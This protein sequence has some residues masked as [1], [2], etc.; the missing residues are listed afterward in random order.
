[1][2]APAR[3]D[4]L[5]L[6]SR[7][8]GSAAVP[9]LVLG[10]FVTLRIVNPPLLETARLQVFDAYVRLAPRHDAAAPV[11]VVDID[12]DTLAAFGQWPWPRT[13]IAALVQKLDGLGAKTIAFDVVFA[14]PDRTSPAEASKLWDASEALKAEARKLPDHEVMLAEAMQQSR[15]VTGFALITEAPAVEVRPSLRASIAH[16]G[17]DPREYVPRLAG[18][19]AN[20]PILEQAS[21]G[22]GHLTLL[23]ESDGM[24]RR[25]PLLLRLG[26]QLYPSL[27]AEALRVAQGASTYVV[28]STGASGEQYS[29]AHTGIVSVKIGAHTVPTDANGRLWIYYARR[30]PART[31]P[32]W[33]VLAGQADASMIH[34]AIVFIG[35]SAIGLKDIRTTPVNPAMA[36]VE[37]HAQAT[38]QI[39]DGAFLARP[40]WADG[41]ETVWLAGLGAL[42]LIA[43]PRAGAVACAGIGAAGIAVALGVSW[44]AFT[45]L[46][47]LL[48]PV[49]PSVAVLGLYLV[50]SFLNFLRTEAERRHVRQA[51]SR[52]LAPALVDRLAKHPEQLRLGGERRTMT[53]LFADIRGFTS[54]AEQ[55]DAE[56]LGRFMNRFLTPMTQIVLAHQGTIDKYVGDC[57]MAFWNAPFDDALH[58]RHACHAALQMRSHLVVFNQQMQADGQG[59]EAIRRPVHIGIGINTGSCTVGNF[60]SEQRFDYSVLGDPVNLASRLEGQSNIYGSD[61]ILGE[62]AREQ[63]PELAAIELDLIL[64][65]GRQHPVRIYA[66]IGDAAMA[67]DERFQSLQRHHAQLLQAYREQKWDEASASLETCLSLDTPRIR[68]RRLYWLYR[69]RI[70]AYRTNPPAEAW[71]GVWSGEKGV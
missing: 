5:R 67:S 42:L 27:A 41:A 55:F 60:G 56:G 23:A 38:E 35:T 49:M 10:V 48:D 43:L 13:L 14:E 4:T 26:D 2:T 29:N 68:L 28:K 12:D 66:L 51:F 36:G 8:L 62:M 20:L 61:I 64:V 52:Y 69:S 22:N 16:A 24:T 57:I 21:T 33:E 31:V 1:V 54:L 18:A 37:V 39:L 9:L 70:E 19:V 50:A 30:D 25:V 63:V 40:D 46:R 59:V 17:D 3:A 7:R 71:D 44:Y 34:N 32:A 47:W 65:R 11:V 53:I 15:V 45:R 6:W 58:T